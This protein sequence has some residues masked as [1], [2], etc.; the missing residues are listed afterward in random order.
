MRRIQI[1][2]IVVAI[3]TATPA[4]AGFCDDLN[5]VILDAKHSFASVRNGETTDTSGQ[6]VPKGAYALFGNAC[7]IGGDGKGY[8]CVWEDPPA[9]KVHELIAGIES[10]KLLL[11]EEKTTSNV[12]LEGPNEARKIHYEGLP[13][14]TPDGTIVEVV[15]ATDEFTA[16]PAKAGSYRLASLRIWLK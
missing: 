9:E 2:I 12:D 14:L 5:K 16:P 3:W 7:W 10:C 15:L 6:Q 4:C 1:A 11:K 8:A 13:I